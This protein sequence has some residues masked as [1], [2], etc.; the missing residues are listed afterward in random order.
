LALSEHEKHILLALEGNPKQSTKELMDSA[1]LSEASVNRASSWLHSKGLVSIKETVKEK[2]ELDFEGKDYLENGLPERRVLGALRGERSIAELYS[3]LGHET[4]KI[5]IVW[6]KR[7]GAIT[8]SDGKVRLT[9]KGEDSSGERMPQERLLK[10]VAERKKIPD[11]MKGETEQLK[12]RGKVLEFREYTEREIELTGEGKRLIE[13]GITI[14]K[15]VSQLTPEMLATGK[16]KEVKLREYDVEAPAPVVYP[17]K[18]HP[19][20]NLIDKMR[21]V[22]IEMGFQEIKGPIVESCFWNFDALFVPQDHPGRELQ[23]T[24]YVRELEAKKPPEKYMENVRKVHEQGWNYKWDP[25]K[26]LELVLR[27]HTTATTCRELTKVK[28]L[29]VK[30]FSI[31]KV[32]RNEVLDYKH[33]PEFYQVEGIVIDKKA[34]LVDLFGILHE[35][36]SRLGFEKIR[37]KPSFFPYTEPSVEPEVYFEKKKSWLE[38]GGAGVFRKEVVE[39]LGIDANVLAWGLGGE[40]PF[41]PL[42]NLD[43]IRTIYKNSLGWIRN[44]ND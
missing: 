30:V 3:E 32:F 19:F 44:V 35:F 36:Y 15:E 34:T 27:T 5:G 7:A 38:L 8:I 20:R 10:I 41:M 33:L 40:R 11:E 24:F 16:W 4:V 31:D 26:A 2:I 9:K 39:P 25:R 18:K 17:G 22:F 21:E 28:E 23:D 37:F 43:D 42:N 14:E 6:L 12:K 29:P 13:K 1:K